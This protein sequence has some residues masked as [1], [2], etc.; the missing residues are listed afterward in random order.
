MDDNANGGVGISI[1]VGMI[2]LGIFKPMWF[3]WIIISFI[4]FLGIQMVAV[5]IND[6]QIIRAHI[7]TRLK[8][9]IARV[10]TE[11]NGS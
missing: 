11:R 5:R 3:L 2:L 6:R 8:I 1:V 7:K 4:G 10:E 9:M